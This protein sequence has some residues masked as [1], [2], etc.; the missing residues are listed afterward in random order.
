MILRYT[1][2][3]K[4]GFRWDMASTSMRIFGQI[5][6]LFYVFTT[7]PRLLSFFQLLV[8]SELFHQSGFYLKLSF[9]SVQLLF[10][11]SYLHFFWG[12]SPEGNVP[13][14]NVLDPLI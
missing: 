3:R 1:S 12:K 14:G 13:G 8:H 2:I 10:K 4:M 5:L 6:S 7:P 9:S 11:K